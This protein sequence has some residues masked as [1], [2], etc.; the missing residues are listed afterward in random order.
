[1]VMYLREYLYADIDRIRS[2]AGQLME[3]IPEESRLTEKRAKQLSLGM[4][5]IAGSTGDWSSEEYTNRSMADSLF[6]ALEEILESD[7]WLNDLSDTL[8]SHDTDYSTL[9]DEHPPGTI[10]RITCP[11]VIFDARFVARVF[12]GLAAASDA[13]VAMNKFSNPVD[14]PSQGKAKPRQGQQKKRT[15]KD[16]QTPNPNSLESEIEDFDPAMLGIDA[17]MLRSMVKL[18]RGVF[19]PGIHLM[20]TPRSDDMAITARL[21]EGRKYLESDPEVLFSRYGTARQTWTMVG[22]IGTYSEAAYADQVGT[23]SILEEGN[24]INRSK[25]AS[26][27]NYFMQF[28]GHQGLADV[29][30]HPGFS[31]VPLAVYRSTVRAKGS[32]IQ[33][34]DGAVI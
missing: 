29:P 34:S 32:A 33:P 1:M 31:I 27:V 19:A 24:T 26:L 3:G 9:P 17:A 2:L 4:K 8:Q 10:V 6:G 28:V 20:L 22:S 11:G 7:G 18:S 14:E 5:A 30:Q 21:Q 16:D 15:G 23:I 13:L 12:S 25:F